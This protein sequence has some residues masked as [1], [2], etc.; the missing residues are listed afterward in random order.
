M[1]NKIACFLGV[2]NSALLR[3]AV[4]SLVL[5]V[6]AGSAGAICRGWWCVFCAAGGELANEPH[7]LARAVFCLGFLE[8]IGQ[9]SF[10]GRKV[11]RR[12]NTTPTAAQTAHRTPGMPPEYTNTPTAKKRRTTPH[13]VQQ[14]NST[15]TT[16]QKKTPAGCYPSGAVCLSH[17]FISAIA[18]YSFSASSAAGLNAWGISAS[19]LSLSVSTSQRTV[20]SA[21]SC[22]AVFS[23]S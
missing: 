11:G 13:S 12:R 7:D 19:A 1:C 3:A 6:G 8:K 5:S 18:Q 15:N 10:L 17:Y 22:K 9:K 4:S 16:G 14:P 20:K 21:L 2:G 23:I